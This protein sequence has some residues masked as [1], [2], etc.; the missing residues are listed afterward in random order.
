MHGHPARSAGSSRA[1]LEKEGHREGERWISALGRGDGGGGVG[2]GDGGKAR[3]RTGRKQPG[4]LCRRRGKSDVL[5]PAP[6]SLSLAL[7]QE[8]ASVKLL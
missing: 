1:G 4:A 8:P 6:A 7:P 2:W 3:M 5:L